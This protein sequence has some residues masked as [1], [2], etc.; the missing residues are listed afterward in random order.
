MSY[1]I[2]LPA[3]VLSTCIEHWLVLS[4]CYHLVDDTGRS[5]VKIQQYFFYS[6]LL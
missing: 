4:V 6:Y 1:T 5:F 3:L 2:S